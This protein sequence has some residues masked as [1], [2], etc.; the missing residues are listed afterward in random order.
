MKLLETLRAGSSGI[1]VELPAQLVVVKDEA[2]SAELRD[3]TTG[4]VWWLF[5]SSG[6]HLD[7]GSPDADELEL[8]VRCY[9]RVMFDEV[10]R[11]TAGADA[12]QPR[13]ADPTWTPM[14]DFERLR[15]DG[16]AALRTVHRMAYRPG[17]EMVMAHLLVP[18]A[19][20]LFEA[21]VLTGEAMTG[22]RE[23]LLLDAQ[24]DMLA[25]VKTL[26]QADYDDP[27]R[28]ASFPNHSLSRARAA[29][30]W[31]VNEAGLKVPAP[32]PPRPAGEV[33]LAALGCAFVPPPRFVHQPDGDQ[34]HVAALRRVSFCATDG[35]EHLKVQ[36]VD[37][38]AR[39]APDK[40]RMRIEHYVRE[41][42]DSADVKD[43]RLVTEEVTVDGRLHVMVSGEGRGHL[44]ALRNSFRWF[45]DDQR[46]AWFIAIMAT[47]AVPAEV[48][49]TELEAAA[50]SWR[51]LPGT[52]TT[53]PWWRPW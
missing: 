36:R 7:L 52:A 10:F 8:A 19:H 40:L 5:L 44:G 23:A 49:R 14:I 29:I 41:V 30:R 17:R 39:T 48:R 11:Q 16:A 33:T 22:I 51:L 46:R 13:T 1:R 34:P 47:A 26:K 3:E 42:H 35:I 18:L 27:A 25:A 50:R 24:P 32:A 4:A 31:L 45:V 20:G 9:A 28:D 53:K 38:L 12:G 2:D 37:D 6:L 43:L 15:V 21:R